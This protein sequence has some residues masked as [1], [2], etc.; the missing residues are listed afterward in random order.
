MVLRYEPLQN[1]QRYRMPKSYLNEQHKHVT[2]RINMDTEHYA[3][4][5]RN[6]LD[7][8]FS[9]PRPVTR[10]INKTRKVQD[11]GMVQEHTFTFTFSFISFVPCWKLI[12][13]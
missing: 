6:N 4:V 9:F 3:M 13:C 7:M 1:L 8:Y 10:I 2:W 11:T 12:Q 5:Q